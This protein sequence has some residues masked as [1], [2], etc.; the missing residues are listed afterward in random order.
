MIFYHYDYFNVLTIEFFTS[1][2]YI[3]SVCR[4]WFFYA[5]R[6][7]IDDYEFRVSFISVDG[8]WSEWTVWGTCSVTCGGGTESRTRTCTN[9]VPQNG[10]AECTGPDTESQDCNTQACAG[11]HILVAHARD[12]FNIYTLVHSKG[13]LS[14]LMIQFSIFVLHTCT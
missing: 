14:P 11:R 5:K 12:S 1:V 3:S 8:G 13:F 10:G 9:P 2:V 7:I 4:S 6:P